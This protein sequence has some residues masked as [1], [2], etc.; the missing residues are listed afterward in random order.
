LGQWGGFRVDFSK[1]NLYTVDDIYALPNGERAE[2]IDGQ[3]YY[4]AS[5]SR[6]HQKILGILYRRIGDYIEKKGGTCEVYMAPFAV[7]INDDNKN[8]VEPD[9]SV[10][11]DANKLNDKGCNGAPDWIIEV[12]SPTSKKMDRLIKLF[13]YRNAGVREY[14][15]IDVTCESITVYNFEQE[16]VNDYTFKD[17]V[18]AGIYEDLE[19]D[20]S[21]I[22]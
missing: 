6:K 5:P 20:F 4:M 16:D 1:I 8:Y 2:L 11:C 9:I 21:D 19:I 17:V 13:K 3:I 14:W 22:K 15:I 7:F 18:K 10:I 12:M